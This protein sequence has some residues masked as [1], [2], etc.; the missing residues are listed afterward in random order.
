LAGAL[1]WPQWDMNSINEYGA[2]RESNGKTGQEGKQKLQ[3]HTHTKD[4]PPHNI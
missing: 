4:V 3:A 1:L 2:G